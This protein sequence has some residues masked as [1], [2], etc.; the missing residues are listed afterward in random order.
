M[1]QARKG[2]Q[3]KLERERG[4]WKDGQGINPLKPLGCGEEF[5]LDPRMTPMH[6]TPMSQCYCDF[7]Y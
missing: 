1:S 4:G 7:H 5:M 6:T 2:G 3:G